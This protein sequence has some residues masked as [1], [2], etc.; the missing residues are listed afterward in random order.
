METIASDIPSYRIRRGYTVTDMSSFHAY[1]LCDGENSQRI[2]EKQFQHA[3]GLF[4]GEI[5][6]LART[7][8][9]L[10]MEKQENFTSA[11]DG[12]LQL[13]TTLKQNKK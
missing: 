1:V 5:M 9:A 12:L 4:A 2:L 3:C 10:T 6:Q 8:R 11:L 13:H 7:D